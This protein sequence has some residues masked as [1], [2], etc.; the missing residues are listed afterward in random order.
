MDEKALPDAF[1]KDTEY[2]AVTVQ[3]GIAMLVTPTCD[4]NSLDV[5]MVCPLRPVAASGLDLGNLRA[6]KYTNLYLLPDHEN[7]D[8]ALLDL[9]DIRSVRPQQFP[10]KNRIASVTREGTDEVLRKFHGSLGRTWGYAPG[11]II[12]PLGKYQTGH[13]VVLSATCMTFK[14]KRSN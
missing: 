10:L 8:E 6:G 11:E 1:E 3:R 5:W 13:F 12:E 2:A 9:T 7:I 4:L 14:C